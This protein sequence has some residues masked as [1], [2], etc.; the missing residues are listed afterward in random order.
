MKII[1]RL[2]IA[3]II[4]NLFIVIPYGGFLLIIEFYCFTVISG[5]DSNLPIGL[6][7]IFSIVAQVTLLF[8]LLVKTKKRKIILVVPSLLI[9]WTIIYYM[10]SNGFENI[11]SSSFYFDPFIFMTALPFLILSIILV[12]KLF[13]NI[14]LSKLEL[15]K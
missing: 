1:S 2:T 12:Y 9:M 15:E 11:F 5:V 13:K 6:I 8:S 14:P 7:G 3:T 10:I 4:L